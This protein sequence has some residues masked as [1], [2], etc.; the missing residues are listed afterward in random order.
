MRTAPTRI[1]RL[2]EGLL[3][4]AFFHRSGHEVARDLLGMIVVRTL[5]GGA[6]QAT[7][8]AGRIVEVEAYDGPGDLACHAS[9]GRTDRT[10]VMFGEAGHAYIYLIYGM[11]CCLN[12]VTGPIDY[13]AAVLVRALEPIEGLERMSPG[14]APSAR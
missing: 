2:G 13:P 5:A 1:G 14:R 10:D 4:R 11:H 6:G 12:V 9:K 7:R 8:L 3:P